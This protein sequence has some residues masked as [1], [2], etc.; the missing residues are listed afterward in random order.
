MST[1]IETT[2]W[3]LHKEFSPGDFVVATVDALKGRQGW[4][5]EVHESK[6]DI[7]V[8]V[9]EQN[10]NRNQ[11]IVE[12]FTMHTNTI[13]RGIP[14][15]KTHSF[16]QQNERDE[17][18]YNKTCKVPWMGMQVNVLIPGHKKVCRTIEDVILDPKIPSG[19]KVTVHY[20]AVYDPNRPYFTEGVPYEYVTERRSR[21]PLYSYRPLWPNEMMYCPQ[22]E[23]LAHERWLF[24]GYLLPKAITNPIEIERTPSPVR[25]CTPPFEGEH[26][27]TSEIIT[28]EDTAWNPRAKVDE[29]LLNDHWIY[30]EVFKGK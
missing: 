20:D 7:E 13:C 14:S 18:G 12:F 16:L 2:Y 9:L 26:P 25:G 11:M 1:T 22:A 29:R 27:P 8:V 24:E 10:N 15:D 21:W 6:L 17:Q 30:N 4:V 3:D 5:I 19:L 28:M 23:V